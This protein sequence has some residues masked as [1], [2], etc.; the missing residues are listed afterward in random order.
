MS[1]QALEYLMFIFNLNIENIYSIL[2]H[3]MLY[4]E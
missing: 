3:T 2:M 4:E 1:K